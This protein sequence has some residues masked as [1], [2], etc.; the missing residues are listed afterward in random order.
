MCTE[1]D[2]IGGPRIETVGEL[3]KFVYPAKVVFEP[4]YPAEAKAEDCCLCP[5]NTT[6]TAAAAGYSEDIDPDVNPF[7][8]VWRKA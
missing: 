8:P 5:V 3:R 4:G 2:V 1:I 6:A 7:G